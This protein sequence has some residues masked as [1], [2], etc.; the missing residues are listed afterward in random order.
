MPAPPAKIFRFTLPPNQFY[1]SPCPAAQEGRSRSSRTGGGMRWTLDA[2]L[3]NGACGG[4]RSGLVLAPEAGVKSAEVLRVQPG[5]DQT[6]NPR[7]T[8]TTSCEYSCAYSLPHSAHEAAGA[9]GTRHSPR[10]LGGKVCKR[11]APCAAQRWRASGVLSA[12]AKFA[13]C[14]SCTDWIDGSVS[15]QRRCTPSPSNR[16]DLKQPTR[17]RI[18]SCPAFSTP[19]FR[20]TLSS[21]S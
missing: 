1:N 6:F 16:G 3:T 8:V 7:A 5:A 18:D 13:G 4:R 20:S 17:Y 12:V 10:P 19:R 14:K 15:P 21:T 2:L 9:S 11:R